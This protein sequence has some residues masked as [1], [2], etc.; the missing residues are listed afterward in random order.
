MRKKIL[1]FVF[2]IVIVGLIGLIV[3]LAM[4]PSSKGPGPGPGPPSPPP[5]PGP[6]TTFC[7]KELPTT[8]CAIATVLDKNTFVKVMYVDTPL[9]NASMDA[10]AD[11]TKFFTPMI[12]GGINVIILAFLSAHDNTTPPTPINYDA[13]KVWHKLQNKQKL[14]VKNYLA[15]HNTVLLCSYGGTYECPLACKSTRTSSKG[16][17]DCSDVNNPCT[18]YYPYG[19]KATTGDPSW[20]ADNLFD[21]VDLDLE[22]FTTGNPNSKC[23]NDIINY[24][25]NIRN[26]YKSKNQQCIITSAPQTPHFNGE[27]TLN[28]ADE[29]VWGN[30]DW[31]N[32]Q[33]YNNSGTS[34]SQN[35]KE[36]LLGPPTQGSTGAC[37]LTYL[38]DIVKIPPSKIV[39]GKCGQGCVGSKNMYYIGA[40]AMEQWF[41]GIYKGI[42]YWEWGS[43]KTPNTISGQQWTTDSTI[44]PC[45][46][47]TPFKLCKAIS[48]NPDNAG[49][50]WCQGNCNHDPSVCPPSVCKC[51][52]VAKDMCDSLCGG[53]NVTCPPSCKA[54]WLCKTISKDGKY[55]TCNEYINSKDTCDKYQGKWCNSKPF[56]PG[57]VPPGPVPPGPVP[58]SGPKQ[59]CNQGTCDKCTIWADGEW[60]NT[61]SDN[62]LHGNCG[63]AWCPTSKPPSPE[64]IVKLEKQ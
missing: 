61:K 45:D 29:K 9:P 64:L 54:C 34:C 48:N 63:K 15:R 52:P 47:K 13:V 42:M 41:R 36:W 33:F 27:Y 56:G 19:D 38:T 12:T 37:N 22:N 43:P 46:P 59:C 20:F 17:C 2:G 16:H 10:S 25:K 39:I 62:C 8:K 49:D 30:F 3:Y 40:K 35:T 1:V 5:G 31:L 6:P 60:C 21:G 24:V 55:C 7:P 51:T 14:I 44:Y 26:A 11:W 58:Y 32:V 23:I 28:Y 53:N 50:K 4:K 57:P 18:Y